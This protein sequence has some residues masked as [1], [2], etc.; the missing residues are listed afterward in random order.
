MRE[1]TAAE[2]QDELRLHQII[3]RHDPT[4]NDAHTGLGDCLAE[5]ERWAEA[6]DAYRTALQHDDTN[7]NAHT[8]LGSCMAQTG[9]W[10][11]AEDAYRTA[12][13]HDD[14]NSNARTGLGNC[15]AQTGRLS[16]AERAYRDAIFHDPINSSAHNGLGYVQWVRGDLADAEASFRWSLSVEDGTVVGVRLGLLLLHSGRTDEARIV[17]EN[18]PTGNVQRELLLAVSLHTSDPARVSACLQAALAASEHPANVRRLMTPF[19]R[20][21]ERAL[22]LAAAGRGAEGATELRAASETRTPGALFEKPRYDL[23]A[24]IIDSADLEPI[25]QV[26][27][28]IITADPHACGPWGP[29]TTP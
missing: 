28:E 12:L 16:E 25:L 8:G 6:E 10:A 13:Q 17:L 1:M 29:P 21:H 27:R 15:M 5:T 2:Q 19:L 7:S 11:E 9:R 4:N 20:A 14:T 22:A 24:T 26:W 23:L 3:V 18:A